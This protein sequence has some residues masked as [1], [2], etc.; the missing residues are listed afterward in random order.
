M[1]ARLVAGLLGISIIPNM[2]LKVAISK[3]S[4]YSVKSPSTA[5]WGSTMVIDGLLMEAL[6]LGF[7]S[8]AVRGAFSTPTERVCWSY[9][10]RLA[11]HVVCVCRMHCF[12]FHHRWHQREPI[13]DLCD[14]LFKGFSKLK[15]SSHDIDQNIVSELISMHASFQ[16]QVLFPQSYVVKC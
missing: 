6:A 2:K 7:T 11:L 8:G 5:N 15:G 3:I 9:F 4:K 13:R 10:I 1:T 16:T 12:F 14:C